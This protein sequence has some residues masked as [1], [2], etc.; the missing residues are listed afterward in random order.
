MIKIIPI[1]TLLNIAAALLPAA[2][3][4]TPTTNAWRILEQGTVNK[5]AAKRANA[6]R[7]LRLLTHNPRAQE[8]AERLLAD[9]DATVRAAAARALGPMGAVSSAPKLKELLSDK[10]PTVVLAAAHSLFLLGD[11]KEVYDIDLELLT[12]E[13]KSADGFVTSQL[14]EL[15]DPRAVAGMGLETGVGFLPFGGEAFEVVKRIRK[16]DHTPVRVAAAKELAGDRD[17]AIDSALTK[18]CSD[19][20]WTVRAAAIYA[21]AKRDNPAFI[22]VITPML[23]DSNEVVRDE[24]AAA[25]LRLAEEEHQ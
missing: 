17:P 19:K 16:D 23:D 11:L 5:R 20:K 24:A 2:P 14:K 25:V 9:P 22:S 13:R 12:G 18:A 8:T 3:S 1:L 21:I 6:V 7:A 15:H 4:P 10:E